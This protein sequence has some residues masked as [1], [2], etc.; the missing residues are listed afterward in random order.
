MRGR[1]NRGKKGGDFKSNSE[2]S[3][4]DPHLRDHVSDSGRVVPSRITGTSASHQRQL[5]KAV[6]IA[7]FL[8]LL[9]YC[10]NH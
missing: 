10:D 9:P 4:M 8:A 1:F 3:Y 2:I 6:K 7:R 5:A